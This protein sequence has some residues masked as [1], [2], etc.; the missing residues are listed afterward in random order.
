MIIPRHILEG[1]LWNL[2]MEFRMDMNREMD[3]NPFFF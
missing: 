1:N 2:E 3:K